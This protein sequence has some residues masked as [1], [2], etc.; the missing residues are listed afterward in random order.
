MGSSVSLPEPYGRTGSGAGGGVGDDENPLPSYAFE[1][2]DGVQS[3]FIQRL[4]DVYQNVQTLALRLASILSKESDPHANAPGKDSPLLFSVPYSH[5]QLHD[6][7][8]HERWWHQAW[9]LFPQDSFHCATI[10]I[11]RIPRIHEK[12]RFALIEEFCPIDLS[13]NIMARESGANCLV[14]PYLG[15]RRSR[16]AEDARFSLHNLPLHRDQMERLKFPGRQMAHYAMAMA[17]ALAMLHWLGEL[18]A[19]GVKFV[20]GSPRSSNTVDSISTVNCPVLDLHAIWVFDFESCRH[21]TMDEKGLDRAV[22]TFLDSDPYYPRPS[23]DVVLWEVF[24][25]FYITSSRQILKYRRLQGDKIQE[26]LPDRFISKLVQRLGCAEEQRNNLD[27]SETSGS[28]GTPVTPATPMTSGS[29]PSAPTSGTPSSSGN[30]GDFPEDE[31]ILRYL[32]APLSAAASGLRRSMRALVNQGDPWDAEDQQ[33]LRFIMIS[34]YRRLPENRDNADVEMPVRL[35]DLLEWDRR[36]R[37]NRGNQ[38]R[39]DVG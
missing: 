11:E 12:G 15:R 33:P 36:N 5:R 8:Q 14:R 2:G 22:S 27:P 18:D 32:N 25:D 38:G 31:G 16:E 28:R 39:S 4:F 17:Q 3:Q 29:A 19:N 10:H 9:L 26:D 37:E 23:S 13:N 20:L 24:E 21:I 6:A 35:E 34:R 7:K 1:Y 30:T